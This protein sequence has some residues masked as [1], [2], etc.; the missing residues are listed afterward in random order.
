M[1][2]MMMARANQDSEAGIMPGEALLAARGK[3]NEGLVKAGVL[4][5]SEGLHPS[6]KGARVRFAG[7][8]RSVIDGPFPER[9]GI[10]GFWLIEVASRDEAIEWAKRRP[11]PMAGESEIEIRRVFEAKDFGAALTAELRQQEERL[12]APA[13]PRGKTL[14]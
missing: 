1:R 7:S 12:R 2:F 5:A 14:R 10:A 8:R 13:D 6:A 3:Y 9:E 4:L 11:N